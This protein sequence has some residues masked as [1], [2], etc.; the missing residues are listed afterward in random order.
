MQIEYDAFRKDLPTIGGDTKFDVQQFSKSPMKMQIEHDAFR[1]MLP[2]IGGE[3]N[4]DV[5]QV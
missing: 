5:P 3:H 4:F 1:K 2:A